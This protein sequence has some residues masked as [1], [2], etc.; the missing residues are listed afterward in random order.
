MTRSGARLP[1]CSATSRG[2]R[3]ALR[4]PFSRF[5]RALPEGTPHPRA[6]DLGAWRCTTGADGFEISAGPKDEE[7][8]WIDPALRFPVKIVRGD[9]SAIELQRIESG[10]QPDSLFEVPA[11]Y[12]R[13]DPER[14]IERIKQSDVWVEP[15]K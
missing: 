9:G 8:R 4:R 12:R 7:K 1:Q 13:F 2:A 6:G 3:D 15:R 5:A 11:G 14:L 10:P